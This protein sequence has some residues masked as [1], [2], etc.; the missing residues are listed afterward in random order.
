MSSPRRET[1]PPDLT[2]HEGFGA[3]YAEHVDDVLRFVTRRVADP[4]LAADLTADVFLAAMGAA[5][6]YRSGRGAPIAWLF[7][8]AR[9]V[10]AGHARGRARES[11]ALA[12]L[13]GRRLLDAEDVAALEE[14]IDAERAFRVLAERHATLSEP[15]RAALD[16]V[17]VDELTPAEAALALGVTQATVRVR[18]HRARRAL[19]AAAPASDVPGSRLEATR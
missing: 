10:V 1:G 14:R 7:G 19:R 8:I 9:N 18:L 6:T 4:H 16:M 13:S 2:N 17:V 11:G 15:L 5:G 12:R 3:F